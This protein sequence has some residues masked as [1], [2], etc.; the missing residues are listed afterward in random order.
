MKPQRRPLESVITGA[1]ILALLLGSIV[2]PILGEAQ[3]SAKAARVARTTAEM[4]L[5]DASSPR[6]LKKSHAIRNYQR[7]PLSFEANQGQT[8][9]SVKY[10]AR[11]AGYQLHL[12]SNEAVF[13]LKGDKDHSR[14]S[15]LDVMRMRLLGSRAEAHIT[16]EELLPGKVNYLLG[17]Q[18]AAW[19]ANLP[20]YRKVKYK[21]VYSGIDL[22]YYGTQRD[23][24][25]DFHVSPGADPGVIS[26]GF[27]GVERVKIDS[28][29]ELIVQF[30]SGKLI[31]QHKPLLYQDVD[32]V[33]QSVT[34]R[35]VMRGPTQ[36]GFEVGPYDKTRTLVI[37]PVLIYA[38][39]FGGETDE[40]TSGIA[41][42]AAGSVYVAG[43]F[44]T[45]PSFPITPNAFQKTQN[46]QN[47]N[48]EVFVTKFTPDGSGIVYSTLLGGSSSDTSTGIGL[49]P[50]GNAYIVGWTSSADFP[51]R[52][53]FQTT[54]R[55]LPNVFISKLN[56]TGSDLLYSSFLGGTSGFDF[57]ADIAV[58]ATGNAYIT[59]D[60][61]SANFPVTTGAFRTTLMLPGGPGNNDGFVAKFNTN[62]SGT[63]SLVYSSF[64]DV[65]APFSNSID[66]DPAGNAYVAGESRVQK[67]NASGSAAVYTFTLPDAAAGSSTGLQATDIAVDSSGNAYVTGFTKSTGL[68]IV[69]G[70]QPAIA[71]GS[72]DGFLVKV[73]PAGTAL[74]YSTYIGGQNLDVA[75]GVAVDNSG[76]AY[77]VGDT[78][79]IDFPTRDAFQNIKLGGAGFTGSDL[80]IA[81]INTNTNGSN[82]LVYS[83]LYGATNFDEA[84][85]GVVID[86]QGN[87]YT[88]GFAFRVILPGIIHTG[89]QMVAEAVALGQIGDDVQ[90]DPFVLKIADTSTSTVRFGA[91][92][93]AISEDAGSIEISVVR[94][95]DV[96]IPTDVEYGTLDGRALGRSDYTGAFGTLHFAAGETSKTFRV[97]ITND[98]SSET[99]ETFFVALRE[100]T[101]GVA[102]AAPSVADVTILDNDPSGSA[103]NPIDNREF[104]VRQHYLDF[105]NREPDTEGF[106][107][108]V[109]KISTSCEGQP[110]QDA[111]VDQRVN[112]SSAFFLSI[113]FSQTGYF[114]YRLHKASFGSLP[115]FVPFLRDTQTVGR[116]VV[117]GRTG[118]ELVLEQ[119]Q[120]QLVTDW[121]QRD[122]F[123]AKYDSL[124]NAQYVDALNTNTGNSLTQSERDALV[125]G[126][127][128]A[129]KTRAEVLRNVAENEEFSRREFS[130]A[131]VLMQ[132]F[133]YL[134]RD[135][136]PAGYQFWLNKLNQFDGDFRRAEMVKAFITSIEYRL[137][138]GSQ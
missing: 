21:N 88:T 95:G 32:G 73:N 31:R 108:W 57:G 69:N 19:R 66:I 38:T 16:G 104:F 59:G 51:I 5:P 138:F 55:G 92:H 1:L 130:A 132:Y 137:R 8:D 129:T 115:H 86:A 22:L 56:T 135:P 18:P 80:F 54:L 44:V 63:A 110:S 10:L 48:G 7:A 43:S 113:E 134:R 49:D 79:S 46:N 127:N 114:V 85:S 77:V 106:H 39:Y 131:F 111:C 91:E 78:S 124:T 23:L 72:F 33:Q 12:T 87:V 83:T 136:D 2:T 6:A 36:V 75:S 68:T 53:A 37:D 14:N 97:F 47:G 126:L 125:A 27:E 30:A 84:A 71:G 4:P 76:N 101:V 98:L 81:K 128:A 82:S 45:S 122:D 117:V 17:N 26:L 61:T 116:D 118:W 64:C 24:E 58:D 102:L 28:T 74:V 52:N 41:V 96:S 133:G 121:V 50:S 67:I 20:T 112:V 34:G 29:G 89:R 62:L 60:T 94:S 99:D 90:F 40:A 35:F 109:D 120:Q 70:F 13:W 123:K 9:P 100:K 42:D 93:L 65:S 105:L 103:I 119:N 25:Y 11:G 15:H 3:G 107:F